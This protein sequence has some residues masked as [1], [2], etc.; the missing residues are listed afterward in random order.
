MVGARVG[1]L[2]ELVVFVAL[3]IPNVS[4]ISIV[5]LLLTLRR[6]AMDAVSSSFAA[7]ALIKF[8]R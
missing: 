6:L 4:K 8:G 3:G 7:A 5:T 2:V 1:A